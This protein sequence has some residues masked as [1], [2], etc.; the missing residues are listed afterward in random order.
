MRPYSAP[1]YAHNGLI[2]RASGREVR[3]RL[4]LLQTKSPRT[5]PLQRQNQNF[6]V[7]AI[8]LSIAMQLRTA[9]SASAGTWLLLIHLLF[10][11]YSKAAICSPSYFLMQA[12]F[13]GGT[14]RCFP[15]YRCN[16]D[17]SAGRGIMS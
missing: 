15:D 14:P 16:G 11:C 12:K 13:G 9:V 17:H 1:G 3:R 10:A 6:R 7:K 8:N 4:H 5:H 2:A